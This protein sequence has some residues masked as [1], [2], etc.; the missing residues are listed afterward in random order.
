MKSILV[1]FLFGLAVSRAPAGTIVEVVGQGLKEPFGTAFDSLGN[2]YVVEMV[3]GNRLFR[4]EGGG[5]LVHL[6]GREE[7]G[8][9]GDGGPARE[10]RFNGPH[11]LAVLPDGDVLIG[12]T[13]NGVVR[14]VDL[15]RGVVTTLPGFRATGKNVK[16]SG[17]YCITLD[18]SGTKLVIADLQRVHVV[19]LATGTCTAVAGNGKKGRPEDG[20]VATEA[21][22]VD[23]RAAALDRKGNLYILERNGNALRVVG[24]DGRIRTV[25]NGGGIKGGEGDGGPAL[26]ATMNG[27]KHLCVDR[28]D[29]VIIADAENH[30]IRRYV[31]DTGRI[32]RVAGTGKPA[33]GKTN[34]DPK[35]C[36]LARPH[37][38]TVHPLT[39]ELYI[40]DS[41][42]DRVLKIVR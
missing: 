2:T 18:F 34:V 22:L 27:P 40:T 16:G 37:G 13:W 3:S 6:A 28:D 32:E 9:D 8:Y 30:L 36:D 23:P 14:K 42:N 26:A 15:K 19:D 31:P 10:A 17:P 25:V 33:K 29:S 5:K 21:P 35:L 11:N 12:D 20:A 38:V 1:L 39:G 41:Y 7:P 24:K 4:V